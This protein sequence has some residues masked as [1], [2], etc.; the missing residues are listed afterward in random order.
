VAAQIV[1]FFPEPNGSFVGGAAN[2]PVNS[3][4]YQQT[5]QGLIRIDQNFGDT[6]KFFVRYGRYHPNTDAVQLTN[7]TANP[8]N[9]GGWWDNQVAMS[10]THVFSPRIYNDFRLGF[11]QEINYDSPGGP[12][13]PQLGLQG[14]P[15]TAFPDIITTNYMQLGASGADHDRDRSWIFSDSLQIQRDRHV[16]KIGG[17]FRREM[18]HLFDTNQGLAS[19]IYSFDQT[20]TSNLGAPTSGWDLADLLLGLPTQTQIQIDNYTYRRISTAR[21]CTFKTISRSTSG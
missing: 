3:T 16:L 13:V 20:F 5:W 18:Y 6:D 15:L 12:P 11:V 10:E 19:G 17:D 9:A 7:N 4:V 1:K 8:N 21:R 14:V 2:Y